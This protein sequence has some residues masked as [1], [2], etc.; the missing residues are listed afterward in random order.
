MADKTFTIR[1]YYTRDIPIDDGFDG[2]AVASGATFPIRIKRF[3][4]AQ[5]Q[6]FQRGFARLTNPTADRF[7]FRKS[8]GDEQDMREAAGRSEFVIP[9]AEI[10]RRRLAEMTDETRAAYDKA[11]EADDSF[12]TSFCSAAITDYVTVDPSFTLNGERENGETFPIRS[13]ADLVE[14]FGGNLSVLIR[15]TRA[16]HQENT[17]SAEAKKTLRSLSDLTASSPQPKGDGPTPA[18]TAPSVAPEATASNGDASEDQETRPSGSI[19]R[20]M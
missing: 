5:L 8:D 2:D 9:D 6:E 4:V 12:M 7:I 15:L 1:N 11:N 17:L 3:S 16:I 13:G 19:P 20:V 18:A 14:A 10:Q